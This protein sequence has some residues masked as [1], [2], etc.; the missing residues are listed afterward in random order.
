MFSASCPACSSRFAADRNDQNRHNFFFYFLLAPA[1]EHPS[2]VQFNRS[3]SFVPSVCALGCLG[4]LAHRYWQKVNKEMRPL[5]VCGPS[6]QRTTRNHCCF[7]VCLFSESL[8]FIQLCRHCGMGLC[9]YFS[10]CGQR[11]TVEY[12]PRGVRCRAS[13][14][15][16]VTHHAWAAAGR[17]GRRQLSLC[18]QRCV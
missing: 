1:M 8:G 4:L 11:H 2:S 10:R 17:S 5:V 16:R 15:R 3:L 13:C 12:V 14:L 18:Q 6:G 7:L 9:V